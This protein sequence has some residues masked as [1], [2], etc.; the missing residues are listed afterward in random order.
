MN[1][2]ASPSAPVAA[3]MLRMETLTLGRLGQAV[4]RGACDWVIPEDQAN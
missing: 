4:A 1:W 2:P 3:I